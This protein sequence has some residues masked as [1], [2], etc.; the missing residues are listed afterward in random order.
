MRLT[1]ALRNYAPRP[2]CSGS[3]LSDFPCA[4][5]E[6]RAVAAEGMHAHDIAILG[7]LAATVDVV[8]AIDASAT[9][10]AAFA[11]SSAGVTDGLLRLPRSSIR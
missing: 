8:G 4:A 5:A 3:Q 6:R 7:T 2:T 9:A 1:L 10:D 11:L